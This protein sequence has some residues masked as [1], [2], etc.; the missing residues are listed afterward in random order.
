VALL[1]ALAFFIVLAYWA[2][3][4]V[5]RRQR[6]AGPPVPARRPWPPPY[7]THPPNPLL[8]PPTSPAQVA[9]VLEDPYALTANGLPLRG[10]QHQL[11]ERAAAAAAIA[12]A[13]A[14]RGP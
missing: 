2:T 10:L 1:T 3:N 5:R 14:G 11:N 12:P 7:P 4:D 13:A 6:A 9:R 8:P